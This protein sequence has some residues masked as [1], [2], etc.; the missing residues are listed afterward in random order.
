[1]PFRWILPLAGLVMVGCASTAPITEPAQPKQSPTAATL[2]ERS[3]TATVDEHLPQLVTR[4]PAPPV[5]TVDTFD[6]VYARMMTSFAL[7]DCASHEVNRTWAR[8]YAERP[9]YMER[10]L[11]RAEPW[12]YFIVEELEARGMPGE[13]ALLPIVESAYDPFAY[14]SSHALGAWQFVSATGR[15]Y[16]LKQDWWYDG[17]RD[18]WA[19][20]H[21]ALDYLEYL[22]A[23]FEGDWLLALA[24]YNGGEGRVSR[25]VKRNRKAGK[26]ADFWN[27]K[28]PEETRG[29]VPKLLGLSCLFLNAE[30]YG[31]EMPGT[32]DAAVIT[33]YDPGSQAD[34]VLVS[35]RAGVPIDQ[36]FTLNPGFNRFATSPEGPYRI[37]L[38]LEGAERLEAGMGNL[39]PEQLMRWDQVTVQSGD[40]LS[41]LAR[42][43]DVPV[44]V[45]R[46][47]NQIKGDAIR[48]GQKLRLPRDQGMLVDPLYAA[49]AAELA[50]L[51]SGLL[52]ADQRS[53]RVRPGESLSVIARRY[54]VSVRDLQR[55]N[56]IDNPNR[57]R[58]GQ[59]I[60]VFLAPTAQAP[61]G[62]APREYTVR[63]GDSLWS[64]ARKHKVKLNDL[65]KWNG[66]DRS[67]VLRPGQSLKILF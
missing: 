26:P 22:N 52:A 2:P 66:L 65:I 15:Q 28:L 37:V 16:G 49:A 40:T 43:H 46:T 39:S 30:A 41:G 14:S 6:S 34:L 9:E 35:Q 47:A 19:S 67:A 58:A 44:D 38:P 60:T 21:A 48:A 1:M 17:R 29:Y 42:T 13:L 59:Q 45:L 62:P 51:Q 20:T 56:N 24:S 23:M 25:A 64:I 36:L 8:W 7:P 63:S 12:I 53:H 50:Q 31:F 5:E 27:L 57:V 4:K 33:T 54:R 3:H 61:A 55:W 32:P 11:A 18:V 10:V